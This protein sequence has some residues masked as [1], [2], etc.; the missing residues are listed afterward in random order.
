MLL[1]V[2]DCPCLFLAIG[3]AAP[4]NAAP[5]R[6]TERY[7]LKFPHFS[8]VPVDLQSSILLC[9]GQIVMFLPLRKAEGR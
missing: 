4:F 7:L 5:C 3:P 8:P 1:A 9:S 6:G 2:R